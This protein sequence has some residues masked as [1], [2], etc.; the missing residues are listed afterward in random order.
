VST[1]IEDSGTTAYWSDL[2]SDVSVRLGK[3]TSRIILVTDI[4]IPRGGQRMDNSDS[5]DSGSAPDITTGMRDSI[6]GLRTTRSD[7]GLGAGCP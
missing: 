1:F 4:L 2:I 3:E 6:M 7:P 5:D